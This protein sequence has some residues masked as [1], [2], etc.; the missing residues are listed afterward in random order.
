MLIKFNAYT[1]T[2]GKIF[3]AGLALAGADYGQGYPHPN[4]SVVDGAEERAVLA[5]HGGQDT[6]CR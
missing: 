1:G 3:A 4:A 2:E 6:Q 5:I